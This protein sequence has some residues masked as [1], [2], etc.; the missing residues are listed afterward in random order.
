MQLHTHVVISSYFA[1]IKVSL[2]LSNAP[3]PRTGPTRL[4][5]FLLRIRCE[6]CRTLMIPVMMQPMDRLTH[7]YTLRQQWKNPTKMTLTNR[8]PGGAVGLLSADLNR[9]DQDVTITR[10][11]RIEKIALIPSSAAI[12]GGHDPQ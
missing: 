1:Q 5:C 11:D 2:C 6:T 7:K 10:V 9:H 4:P 3:W 12:P 8:D